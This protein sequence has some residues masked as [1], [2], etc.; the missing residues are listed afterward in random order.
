[1]LDLVID[2]CIPETQYKKKVRP[3]WM[4]MYCKKLIEDKFRAW[5]KYTYLRK[6]EDYEKYRKIRNKIPKCVRHARRKYE[7]GIARDVNSNPKAFWKYVHSKS[8]VKSG[9]GDL[10]DN[11]GNNVTD[12]R[13]KADILN[14]FLSSVQ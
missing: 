6:R 7:K 11:C 13:S 12:D 10:K 14:N 1:M 8:H 5:K 9:I 3:V 2:S 4:D